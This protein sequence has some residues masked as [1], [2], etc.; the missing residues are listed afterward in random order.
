MLK[1]LKASET[2]G[3]Y[4][5]IGVNGVNGILVFTHCCYTPQLR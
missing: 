2:L 4:G 1:T 3:W 5:I